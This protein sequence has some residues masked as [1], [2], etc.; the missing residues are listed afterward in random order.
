MQPQQQMT[1]CF[2][3]DTEFEGQLVFSG[4]RMANGR[5]SG[6]IVAGDRLTV[7]ADIPVDDA[8]IHGRVSQRTGRS[9]SGVLS[10]GGKVP[11]D[12][13]SPEIILHDRGRFESA[14]RTQPPQITEKEEGRPETSG[15]REMKR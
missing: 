3:T 15:I 9:A 14:C 4:G 5:F 7:A 10:P 11:G 12:I 2:G 13:A 6:G 1:T 8:C